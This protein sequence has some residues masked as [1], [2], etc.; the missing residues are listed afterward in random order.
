MLN[1]AQRVEISKKIISIPDENKSIDETIDLIDQEI[2]AAQTLDNGNKVYFDQYNALVNAYQ[3]EIGYLNGTGRTQ[4]TETLMQEA[5]NLKVGNIF[6]PN[7]SNNIPPSLSELWVFMNPFMIGYGI[8]KQYNESYIYTTNE[9]DLI[10]AI[11]ASI[12]TIESFSGIIRATGKSCT[13][14]MSPPDTIADDPAMQ[15]A[16]TAI[17]NDISSLLSVL[18]NMQA[19]IFLADSDPVRAAANQ[20]A[21][22]NITD[23]IDE[24]NLWL[25]YPTFT[26]YP[27]ADLCVVFNAY[28]I[29]LLPDTKYKAGV[30]QILKDAITART[31]QLSA[32]IS[33][34]N[35]WLGGLSQNI[36]NGVIS[37][38]SGFYGDRARFIIE[39]MHRLSGSL[40][41]LISLQNGVGINEEFK[42]ANEVSQSTYSSIMFAT[43]FI[44]PGNKTTK[45]FVAQPN[46][47]VGQIA[48]VCSNT[49]PELEVVIRSITGNQIELNKE[50][51]STYRE[52]EGARLYRML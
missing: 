43:K 9:N 10:T 3:P 16:S 47:S 18:A 22:D 15:A 5:A 23:F 40:Q 33:Q 24:I 39:R 19:S 28:D 42:A 6:F 1:S 29:S 30:L 46:F 27:G 21:Y 8:G 2:A 48:Y 51:P 52:N 49:Q 38:L 44:A 20:T 32:R 12:A 37:N 50:I 31:P 11:N 17:L 13:T 34:V 4:V 45:I 7:D 25:A 41:K 36:A 35:G 14:N 26:T